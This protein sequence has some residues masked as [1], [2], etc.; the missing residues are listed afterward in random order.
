MI[1]SRK[2]VSL[3]GLALLNISVACAGDSTRGESAFYRDAIG[4]PFI[5]SSESWGLSL[6]GAGVVKGLGQPQAALFGT[7]VGSDNGSALGYLGLYNVMVPGLDQLQ[8]D[9]SVLESGM[10]YG[11]YFVPG[12]PDYPGE[13]PGS[14]GSGRDNYVRTGS[15]NQYYQV[16]FQYTLPMG[17]GRDGALA[18]MGK[19][20]HGYESS[21]NDW[22]PLTTGITTLE[23]QPYYKSQR[24]DA[25]QPV[26]VAD[27]SAGIRL[28]L[29]YDNRNS[30]QLPTRGSRTAFTYTFDWGSSDRPDWTTVEFEFSKFF[31]LG[32]NRFMKQ[33][34][35]A[36]NG[37]VADTPTW[38][39]TTVVNGQE[40]YRRA[41]Y[42]VGVNLGG[43]NKLRG[44]S[45]DRFYGRSAISYSMEY[46]MMPE[47]QPL[48]DLPLL[49]PIYDMPWWQ[50]TLF[51]DVGRVADDF[52]LRELHRDMKSS[53]GGGIRF[54][55]EG[56]TVRTEIASSDE[57]TFF[58]IFANQP[59]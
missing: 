3:G 33:Q 32:R 1:A 14:N 12:N 5:F 17:D 43:W 29:E 40:V 16:F 37:W 45:S 49:G 4:I 18:A 52:D 54:A 51:L 53:A 24:L 58:R 47:W 57:E 20:A 21:H 6:A 22:N 44:Y 7:V 59:F 9:F 28:T 56:L 41:P 50:W 48:E 13:Q 26:N 15:R 25:F 23:L 35:L 36:F 55:I 27:E 10:T 31:S 19:K 42:F 2:I 38:N 34:V 39:D 30:S 11:S 46:R 8:M